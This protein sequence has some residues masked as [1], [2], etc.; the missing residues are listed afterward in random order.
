MF[1]LKAVSYGR[2]QIGL[3]RKHLFSYKLVVGSINTIQM[4]LAAS[5]A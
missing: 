4:A 3:Y 5:S 1:G 2:F